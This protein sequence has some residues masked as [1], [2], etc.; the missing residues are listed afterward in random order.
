MYVVF[1]NNTGLQYFKIVQISLAEAAREILDNFAILFA[2]L[3]PNT[4]T[5]L[6]ITY[7]NYDKKKIPKITLLWF[8]I[9]PSG[10]N[11]PGKK[12][13]NNDSSNE[14]HSN[15]GY[16]IGSGERAVEMPRENG[17][18]SS[19]NKKPDVQHY[20]EINNPTNQSPM[21]LKFPEANGKEDA[22]SIYQPL[23]S[24]AVASTYQPLNTAL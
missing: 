7:T 16:Y 17:T 14:A 23:D 22:D 2:V 18:N 24:G 1:K 9:S 8:I 21:V 15:Y 4:T 11:R 19:V 10:T 6:A 12:N 3:F 5:S 13:T 20:T